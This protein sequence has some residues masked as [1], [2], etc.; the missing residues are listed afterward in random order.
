MVSINSPSGE[1]GGKVMFH[2]CK[3]TCRG[4]SINSPSGEGGGKEQVKSH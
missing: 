4:V 1:G 3:S 2:L